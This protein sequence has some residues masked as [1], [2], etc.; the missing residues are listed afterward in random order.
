MRWVIAALVGFLLAPSAFAGD[1]DVLRGAQYVGPATFTRWSGFY[2]GGQFGYTDANTD[3]SGATQPLVAFSLR[4]LAVEVDDQVSHFQAL[5]RASNSA[6]GF[7]GFVG[8][9]TQWQDLILGL[10]ANYSHTSFTAVA[11]PTPF[12]NRAFS[13]GGNVYTVNITGTGSLQLTDYGSLRARAGWVFN[14]FLPYGFVGVALGRADYQVTSHVYGQQDPST[15]PTYP[16][17][18]A[19]APNCVD[20]S[21]FNDTSKNSALLYGFTVGGGL[22][23][24][25]TSNIFLR[26]EYQYI[27]FAPLAGIVAAISSAQ[28]GVGLKF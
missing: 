27:R 19:I 14:N 13:A 17:D 11:P 8:Y 15:P 25:L 9:N 4:G 3:F 10:E 23:M 16:C 6:A 7:G 26:G 1:Y 28:V 24:A 18:N 22:D 20:Y 12:L 5:G 21:F 2:V